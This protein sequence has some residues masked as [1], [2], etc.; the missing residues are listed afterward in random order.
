LNHDHI[1]DLFYQSRKDGSK[2]LYSQ[3]LYTL[4]NNKIK[5]IPLPKQ[6][7]IKG[8]FNDNFQIQIQVSTKI[9]S[10]PIIIDVE[11]RAKNYI[12][13][14]I[15]N[16]KGKLLKP[17][18]VMIAPIAYYEPTLISKSKGYGLKSFQQISGVAPDDKLGN[19]ETLWYYEN[20]GWIILQT[21]WISS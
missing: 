18:T 2:K 10:N 9:N 4:K 8:N 21:D 7:Y 19:I 14:G 20:G 15:Y 1:N 16:K 5:E 3:H 11:D 12:K 17:S 13:H 6:N